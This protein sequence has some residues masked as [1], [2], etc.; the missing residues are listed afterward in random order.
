MSTP[1]IGAPAVSAD[2]VVAHNLLNCYVREINPGVLDGGHL[3]VPL[4]RTG[5]A[6]RVEVRR[7]S[8]SG[9][10]RFTGPARTE[11]GAEAAWWEVAEL[12]AAELTA[13]TGVANDEFTAQVAASHE[14]TET[15]LCQR[16][17]EHPDPYLASEQ[18]LPLGHRFHPSP[19]ARTATR[20]DWR[21]YAP[22]TGSRI[23]L[24]YLAVPADLVLE[25]GELGAIDALRPVPAGHRLLPVHPW[26]FDLLNVA[27][28]RLL[29]LGTG[30]P[31][32]TPTSSV[33]TLHGPTGFLKFSL[34]VRITN[35]V[36]RNAVYE[37][38]SAVAL[39]GLLDRIDLPARVLREPG[40][41]TVDLPG[42]RDG[43]G[44]IVRDDVTGH[45]PAAAT[46]L[47]AAA[48][49]DEYPLSDAH[50]SRLAG[51]DVL[52]WWAA[53]LRLLVPPVLATWFDH[54]VVLE[55]HLQ[56]VLVCVAG[57]GMPVRLLFRDLEGTK[58]VADRHAAT[59]AALPP[60]VAA[61]LAYTREQ[62][63]RRVAYCLLVNHVAEF[64]AALADLRP[65]LEPD[66]WALVRRELAGLPRLP[67][68]V[69][70]V[71]A[72][73]PVPAKANLLARWR[74]TNDRG[75]GYVPIRL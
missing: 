13:I 10:H 22:E 36:R 1:T 24:R 41:R 67:P 49:A 52:G 54:G 19:K 66:L 14:V 31:L 8:L 38:A 27:D 73:G 64:V 51:A 70:A 33:R 46:P 18:S 6:L 12:V 59:L 68:E 50:V 9:A 61:S 23:A 21:D 3:V 35:C 55:P 4:P 40:Y 43:L 28:D 71:L 15:A 39:T 60:D 44:V 16:F 57:D 42:L 37:L 47:L 72:G 29:D 17:H 11:H 26:Q 75:A 7:R 32:C 30:G 53:Y 65:E 2:H 69:A 58:L 45:L 62:A 34:N 25:S 5:R 74:R 20:G 56:N 63:W 48:V